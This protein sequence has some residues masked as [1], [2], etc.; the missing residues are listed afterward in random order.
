MSCEISEMVGN[1]PRF[2][3]SQIPSKNTLDEF[4]EQNDKSQSR[5]SPPS[6]PQI[7]YV[8][9]NSFF[10]TQKRGGSS[11]VSPK[12][13]PNKARKLGMNTSEHVLAQRELN[14]AKL[15]YRRSEK[16]IE[17]FAAGMQH[18]DW[19]GARTEQEINR[20]KHAEHAR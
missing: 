10:S 2:Y 3:N 1:S 4:L 12:M 18:K 16:N 19:R 13:T 8:Q 17:S 20:R 15:E 9:K 5:F 7:P 6:G 11:H 14:G